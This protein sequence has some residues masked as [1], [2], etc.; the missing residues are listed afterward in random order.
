MPCA[1]G[2]VFTA[3]YT[4]IKDMV[5]I[6]GGCCTEKKIYKS[7]KLH[8]F[9]RPWMSLSISFLI[10][11]SFL[12]CWHPLNCSESLFKVKSF[13]IKVNTSSFPLLFLFPDSYARNPPYASF[14]VRSKYFHLY[15]YEQWCKLAY[16]CHGL[17]FLNLS[18][19]LSP[20]L[21]TQLKHNGQWGDCSSFF[22][23][24]E[25]WKKGYW[26]RASVGSV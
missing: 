3:L 8:L 26:M 24:K 4:S 23:K 25:T 15:T 14:S 7:P 17:I 6:R 20:V 21:C 5:Q 9:S 1:L 10:F 12:L 22:L 18:L 2:S 16:I 11:Y 19:S 13:S